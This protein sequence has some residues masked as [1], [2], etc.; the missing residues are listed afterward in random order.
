[1]LTRAH[2][3]GVFLILG[4]NSLWRALAGHDVGRHHSRATLHFF[5]EQFEVYGSQT[6]FLPI[7]TIAVGIAWPLA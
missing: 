7:E 3:G 1:L 5:H 2:N 6:M 4:Q